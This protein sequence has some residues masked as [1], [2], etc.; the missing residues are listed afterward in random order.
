MSSVISTPVSK[1]VR[2]ACNLPLLPV[3]KELLRACAAK[4]RRT[5]TAEIEVCI[6]TYA[7]QT[8]SA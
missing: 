8:L 2:K 5:L 6:E 4:N 7:A 3:T 1:P